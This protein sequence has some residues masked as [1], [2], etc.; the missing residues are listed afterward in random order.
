M[1]G[2][3]R[4]VKA[5][6]GWAMGGDAGPPPLTRF[7]EWECERFLRDQRRDV[8]WY[9]RLAAERGGPVLE[10]ACGAGRVALALAAEGLPVLGLDLQPHMVARATAMAAGA[11]SFRLGD[12]RDFSLGRRFALILLP[13]NSLGYL[14]TDGEIAGC[15]RCV[16]AHLQPGGL[17]AFQISPFEVG[18]PARPRGFLARAPFEDGELEMYEAV[19]AE[20]ERHLTHY[21][22]EYHLRRPGHPAH[23]FR[24]RLTLRSIYRGEME[25]LLAGAGLRARA[26]HGDFLGRPYPVPGHPG[27]PMLFEA[28]HL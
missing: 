9:R 16:V 1:P 4:A 23:I 7:Y 25:A 15:L 13:Y 24:E 21:D 5:R 27:G 10:L 3:P 8:L 28:V 26:V 11:A 12:M 14:L 22:E 17:F 19:S 2:R 20:P 6:P 18:E